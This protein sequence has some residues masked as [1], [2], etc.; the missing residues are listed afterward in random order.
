MEAEGSGRALERARVRPGRG[1]GSARVEVPG[2]VW[3]DPDR[4]SSAASAL[5]ADGAAPGEGVRP[6]PLSKRLLDVTVALAQIVLAAPL[7]ILIP[8]AIRLEDG[9]PVFFG[10]ER[11]G[12]GGETFTS[13]KFRSMKPPERTDGPFRQAE[14]EEHRITRVGRVLRPMALDELPQLWNILRGEMSFVGP[15]ALL[16]EEREAANGGEPVRLADLPG[17][18]ER[19]AVV[20]GLTGLAQVR[21]PRH[22]P[23][24]DKFRYDR[25]YV[26]RRTLWL[27]V[28]LILLSF[29]ISLRGG[30]PEV[31]QDGD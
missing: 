27:D 22:L 7:W 12:K 9:G 2:T 23:H 3:R 20:P 11:V 13:Y 17:Y 15:R 14:L 31:G 28:K 18:E 24:R 4:V 30:W 8:L 26:R 19:H 21:A 10:Q 16:A 29:W 25:V 6:T 1:G 5:A